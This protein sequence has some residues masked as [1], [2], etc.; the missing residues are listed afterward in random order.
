[1]EVKAPQVAIK[2][3]KDKL[4]RKNI[5]T[6]AADKKQQLLEK[7]F[8]LQNFDLIVW[9]Y[10]SKSESNNLIIAKP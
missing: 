7:K 8:Q 3:I 1:M 4:K 10:V 9:E 5:S 6:S 2:S